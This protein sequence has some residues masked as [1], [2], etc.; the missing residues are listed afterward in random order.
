MP[1]TTPRV[2][3][4]N[5]ESLAQMTHAEE[6]KE[7]KSDTSRDK[8]FPVNP[9]SVVDYYSYAIMGICMVPKMIALIIPMFIL[10]WPGV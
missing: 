8:E 6:L 2:R 9:M 1:L 10:V 7:M 4:I 5:G 3:K